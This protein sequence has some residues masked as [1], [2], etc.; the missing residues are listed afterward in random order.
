MKKLTLL[1]VALIFLGFMA[2]PQ[3]PNYW[4]K[5]I[6]G[7]TNDMPGS[8]I[9]DGN[10]NCYIAGS[11]SG[12][13]DFDP[14]IGV[15]SKTSK[16]G[17]DI[18]L[19]KLNNSG[20]Y[21]WTKT[22]GSTGDDLQA[23]FWMHNMLSV[24]NSNNVFIATYFSGSVDFDPGTGTDIQNSNGYEDICL[25]KINADGSY[26]WTK[27]LGG[28]NTEI[29]QSCIVDNSGNIYV[30][31]SVSSN[32]IDFD[33]GVGQDLGSC[34]PQSP[35]IWKINNNG[36]YGWGKIF[37][38][39]I[40]GYGQLNALR[41]DN[42]Q[43]L[44]A[45]G[46]FEYTVDFNPETGTDYKSSG[47]YTDIFLTK[48]NSDYSYG[49]TKTI[50]SGTGANNQLGLDL[51]IKSDGS[52][53]YTGSIQKYSGSGSVDMD[54]TNGMDIKSPVNGA[55]FFLTKLSNENTYAWTKLWTGTGNSQ[56]Q[57]IAINGTG[58]YYVAGMFTGTMDFDPGTGNDS[59]TALSASDVFL[60]KFNADDSYAWTK[61][62]GGTGSN[63][64][65][66]CVRTNNNYV[67]LT[68]S[69]TGTID[70][71][72][73][74]NILQKT[75]AGGN[76]IFIIK[77]D[78]NG[79]LSTE[80][81]QISTPSITADW[82]QT[83]EVPITTTELKSD[84]NYISYQF[85]LNYDNTKLQYLNKSLVGTIADNGTVLVNETT[86]GNLAVSYMTTNHLQGSGNILNLQFN[87][88]NVGNAPIT[89]SNFLYNNT[90]VTTN[91]G[92]ITVQ[93]ITPPTAAITYSKADGNVRFGENLVI[94]ATFSE[95]MV[96]NPVP[97][98]VLSGANTLTANNMTKISETV[99]TYTHSGALG[100]G[101]VTVSVV[102]GT[103]THG[104]V[105]ISTPTIGNTFNVIPIT[106]GDAD[107]NTYIRAYDAALTL[108]YSVGLDPL[109]VAD[110]LPW[111]AW[112]IAT[113][114]VDG[115]GSITAYDA[116]L[117]LQYSAGIITSFP[118]GSKKSGNENAEIKITI[119]K[120]FIQFRSKG[121]LFGLN[122]SIPKDFNNLGQPQV[123][124]SDM[125]SAF[126][127]N[128]TTYAVGLATA[129][130]PK[131]GDVFLKIPIV[132]STGS[133]LIFNMTVNAE[134][135]TVTVN[136]ATGILEINE[137]SL[138]MFPNPVTN[139]LTI[140][141]TSKNATISIYDLT[142][143][144]L[145][146][147]VAKSATEI[148]DVSGLANGAYTVKIIDNKVTKT[149]K[150]IKQ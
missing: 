68:C 148:I 23:N 28:S 115:A 48:I 108:Q 14:G 59:K 53:Y 56:G 60:I 24:D 16:G 8:I 19:S 43:N 120:K 132:G 99:Y 32:S 139:E 142:G 6:G 129:Y 81:T 76:D 45:L 47:G 93:D 50:G 44:F 101:A 121:D 92:A 78:A 98:I 17:T 12:T 25:I 7:S 64:D 113:A 124:N 116:S 114:N 41:F 52:Q 137:S 143:K 89:I 5:T 54:P 31:G 96:N 35:F 131:N 138:S 117:I 102:T 146:R 86:S 122:I 39:N 141:N 80:G 100:N 61:T 27:V 126:N 33:P 40:S 149:G 144:L 87:A 42:S 71:D 4:V 51:L 84:S 130:P 82:Q 55:D 140:N 94:T 79:N 67:Y 30:G 3:N 134:N 36:S 97:Q 62:F 49:G 105:V 1:L 20:N 150:L 119:D 66:A 9:F 145:I 128:Q 58:D 73:S 10:R 110:P 57:T 63:T 13:V 135:V 37:K 107:D 69:F 11:F 75:S 133:D 136:L 112:R 127:I 26:G 34:V 91:N 125:I 103:D 118:A 85:N 123:L 106:Y 147:R 83:F 46:G 2:K 90:S 109:P 111:E 21:L 38:M 18:F 77:L 70:I 65:N 104:N 29:A 74:N 95:P 22:F 72:P 15:D 88:I